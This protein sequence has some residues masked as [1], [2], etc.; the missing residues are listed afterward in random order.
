[1][2]PNSLQLGRPRCCPALSLLHS[3]RLS[4]SHAFSL[5]P[6]FQPPVGYS[7]WADFGSVLD[8]TFEPLSCSVTSMDFFDRINDTGVSDLLFSAVST[9]LKHGRFCSSHHIGRVDKFL[10][11]RFVLSFFI[12]EFHCIP[13][14]C[15]LCSFPRLRA[16]FACWCMPIHYVIR[17]PIVA[18]PLRQMCDA[19]T[20]LIVSTV[21]LCYLGFRASSIPPRM[22]FF[23]S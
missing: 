2:Y 4:F 16:L 15:L 21:I 17:K 3:Q 14:C 6:Y 13:S 18:V 11:C 12:S 23:S 8:V 19:L 1:M 22:L 10:F 9:L 7:S 20:M 5:F